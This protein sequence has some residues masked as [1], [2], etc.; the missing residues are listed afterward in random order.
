MKRLVILCFLTL[1]ATGDRE[2]SPPS[3][4]GDS[5][6]KLLSDPSLSDLLNDPDLWLILKKR[7]GT[8]MECSADSRRNNSI[9]KTKDS[10]DAGATFIAAPTVQ[11]DKECEKE[12]C[13]EK[14]CNTAVLKIKG[15]HG[16]D[17]ACYLF[18]C[19]SPNRCV[20][21]SHP[22]FTVLDFSYARDLDPHAH[23]LDQLAMTSASTLPSTTSTTTTTTAATTTVAKAVRPQGSKSADLFSECH[24][25]SDCRDQ[26]TDCLAGYCVCQQGYHVVEMQ[27]RRD[28][29][30]ELEFECSN[31]GSPLFSECIAVY[32][33]CDGIAQCSDG[34][35]ESSCL[36][37]SKHKAAD[38][39][40]RVNGDRQ[41][42]QNKGPPITASPVPETQPSVHNIPT[43]S[44]NPASTT[45]T[46]APPPVKTSLASDPAK[47]SL[48]AGLSSTHHDP[49]SVQ[50]KQDSQAPDA[51]AEVKEEKMERF[52]LRMETNRGA[53]VA[54]ILGIIL[55]TTLLILAGCRLRHFR[56]RYRKGRHLNSNEADYL[57]NGM[58][59]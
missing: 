16:D 47:S 51:N 3:V 41:A 18:D 48:A 52:F 4:N 29:N 39:D 21:T 14:S 49:L 22:G 36:E 5:L 34:S 46:E 56:K 8:P 40:I 54:L 32:D 27:C 6:N 20:F 44:P 10:L 26:N 59:L 28:C 23:D 7:I 25:T 53:V 57:I 12:C 9:I 2:H 58:Y 45:A 11:S 24:Q 13:K 31:K 33:Y 43:K 35:D 42:V 30:Q 37:N 15:G 1:S 17:L 50:T 38:P 55:T 19:K